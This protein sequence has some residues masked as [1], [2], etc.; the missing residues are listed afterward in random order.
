[1]KGPA[2]SERAANGEG[3]NKDGGG[4]LERKQ[5]IGRKNSMRG[6]ICKRQCVI[7]DQQY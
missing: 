2:W 5:G 3:A 4:L 6:V 1:M 7:A